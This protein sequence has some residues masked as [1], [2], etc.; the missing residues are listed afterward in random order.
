MN[1][2]AHLHIASLHALSKDSNFLMGNLA[3]DFFVGQQLQNWSH[4]SEGILF[5]RKID[6]ITDSHPAVLKTRKL[7]DSSPRLCHG[8]LQDVFFDYL[9]IQN[10]SKF[11][12]I[13]LSQFTQ[14]IYVQ[15]QSVQKPIPPHLQQVL[16][17]YI[18]KNWLYSC[19]T[20][21]SVEGLL[22]WMSKRFKNKIDLRLGL[23]S[24]IKNKDE[25]ELLF[26]VFYR[27]LLKIVTY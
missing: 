7:L 18:E 8:I 19:S 17:T 22:F 10:W 25:I 27:E 11:S 14:K 12:E 2:L 23:K 21:K 20:L 13:P 3:A 26:L 6:E 16:S 5:H 9:L 15:L 4:L 24:F 1:H